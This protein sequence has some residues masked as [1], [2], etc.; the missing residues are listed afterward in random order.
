MRK[1]REIFNNLWPLLPWRALKSRKKSLDETRKP[2]PTK[3]LE[4]LLTPVKGADS[5]EHKRVEWN[6]VEDTQRV[7]NAFIHLRDLFYHWNQ[8][9]KTAPGQ[10]PRLMW[11]SGNVT[12]HRPYF[13]IQPWNE[14]GYLF[15]MT[16][17]GWVISRAE[18]II[19]LDRF[20][21]QLTAWDHVVLYESNE[22]DGTLRVKADQWGEDLVSMPLYEDAMIRLFRELFPLESLA[23]RRIDT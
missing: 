13:F 8:K 19:N 10:P 16:Q 3:D 2:L 15:E 18:K 21:R 20:M 4:A 12:G 9:S 22:L 17:R 7:R 14:M 11:E 23:K 5:V 1:T 6:P